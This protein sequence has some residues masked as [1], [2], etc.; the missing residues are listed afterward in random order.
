MTTDMLALEYLI[1]HASAVDAWCI[2]S[3][4]RGSASF[5]DGALIT[6]TSCDGRWDG[7]DALVWTQ[8][9]LS[10]MLLARVPGGGRAP[11][12]ALAQYAADKFKLHIIVR[13]NEDAQPSLEA[14]RVALYKQWNTP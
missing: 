7:K 8:T 9:Y 1:I 2:I 12:V 13:A 14:G 5:C 6:A 4:A 3:S 11:I 10:P